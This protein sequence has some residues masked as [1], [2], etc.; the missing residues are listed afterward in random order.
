MGC[1]A[2][3]GILVLFCVARDEQ[4]AGTDDLLN[5]GGCCLPVM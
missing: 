2:R 5:W 1:V 3:P 4:V